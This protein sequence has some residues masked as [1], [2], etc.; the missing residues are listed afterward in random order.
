MKKLIYTLLTGILLVGVSTANAVTLQPGDI[1]V[2]TG[3]F[4]VGGP[5]KSVILV[6]PV[7]GAQT[8][9]S[10]AGLFVRP[11]HLVISFD[12]EIFV[13][14]SE[15]FQSP[16][17]TG[18]IRVDPISGAQTAVSFGGFFLDAHDVDIEASG[19]LIV[20]DFSGPSGLGGIIRVDPDTGNQT[21]IF[22]AEFATVPFTLAV[23]PTGDIVFTRRNAF[24]SPLLRL[25]PNTGDATILNSDV[26]LAE[27][28]DIEADGNILIANGG[29]FSGDHTL[30]SVIRIDPATG[31]ATTVSSGGLL[32]FLD[33]IAVSSSGDIYVI[34][35][36]AVIRVD[37][38]SGAQELVSAAAGD[39]QGIAVVPV[40]FSVEVAIDIMPGSDPNSINPGSDDVI[41]VAILTTSIADGDALDFDA[42]QVDAATLQF[43]PDGAAVAHAGGHA[44]D[45]DGDGD[46]D[47]LV[48][49]P[50]QDTGI[51]CG[52]IEATLT[53]ETFSG[54]LISKSDSVTTSGCALDIT[55]GGGSKC[56]IATAA[57][58]SYLEPEVKLLRKFRDHYLL[59]N[60]SG[61]AFVGWYYRN[62]PPIAAAIAE[63]A[64]LRLMTR[65][66]LTPLVYSIKYPAAAGL[67]MLVMIIA[68]FGWIRRRRSL[69]L[70]PDPVT[71]LGNP[72]TMW[73][74]LW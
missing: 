58:G 61:Q 14:E 26:G 44:E 65:L 17:G 41:S 29:A 35:R 60:K 10:S 39:Y 30:V 37:P 3:S 71:I 34:Q 25:D 56:F 38:F 1:V 33:G 6:D 12:R 22:D 45:V 40:P 47:L 43:G 54:Q 23:E 63:H 52:D 73:G 20:A 68:S 46:V 42:L 69:A 53:G 67:T 27:G 32:S 5:T 66:A 2:V 57:Y 24:G 50:T 13:I 16:M 18:I 51:I 74:F 64:T 15:R 59:P 55:L 4:E 21:L 9:I 62:S 28:V 11:G 49:F 70:K 7:S 36:N 48:H 8:I 72:A 19:D 31:A